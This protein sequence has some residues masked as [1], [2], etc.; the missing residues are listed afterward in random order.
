MPTTDLGEIGSQDIQ[1]AIY[2]WKTFYSIAG[3]MYWLPLILVMGIFKDNRDLKML[4]ILVP[5]LIINFFWML[6]K[7]ATGGNSS[8]SIPL[9]VTFYSFIIGFSVFWLTIHKFSKYHGI[10]KFFLYLIIMTLIISI[11]ILTTFSDFDRAMGLMFVFFI[12]MVSTSF[13]CF[14]LAGKVCKKQYQPKKFMIWL[15]VFLPALGTIALLAYLAVGNSIMNSNMNSRD[16]ITVF[17]AGPL[18]GLF[19]YAIHLP[20]LIMV[21]VIPFYR[22]RLCGYLK[23]K[24]IDEIDSIMSKLAENS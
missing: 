1:E 11:G 3:S 9:D 14:A 7:Q 10:V 22:E 20:F 13:L 12:L 24:N 4:Y 8:N 18:T 17:I 21:F 6:F 5:L 2:N 23:L 19:I 15:A 16:L